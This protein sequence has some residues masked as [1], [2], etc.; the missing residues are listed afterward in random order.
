[1]A[2]RKN[3]ELRARTVSG[4]VNLY[5]NQKCLGTAEDKAI[6]ARLGGH[7]YNII[8]NQTRD[9]I[10]LTNLRH[11]DHFVNKDNHHT[12]HLMGARRRKY[13]DGGDLYTVSVRN[14]GRSMMWDVMK[15]PDEHPRILEKGDFRMEQAMNQIENWQDFGAFQRRRADFRPRT[16]DKRYTLNNA[17]YAHCLDKFHPRISDKKSWLAERGESM[18]KSQST[19]SMREYASQLSEVIAQDAR[20]DATQRQTESAQFAGCRTANTY[21][22]SVD[23]TK[24][25]ADLKS[26]Q[27]YCSI[28]RLENH[29]FAITK[30]NNHFSGKDKLTRADAYYLRPRFAQTN[31]SVKYDIL[32]NERRF[33]QYS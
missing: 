20:K 29:D 23:T 6:A 30:K 1:M 4:S 26:Q 32:N 24:L 31:N 14:D 13:N 2:S 16:G 3:D 5:D 8:N 12:R 18:R 21:S 22:H 28:N 25:G 10:Y 19:P 27:Q 17:R 33:Y 9:E 7:N 11:D 15:C